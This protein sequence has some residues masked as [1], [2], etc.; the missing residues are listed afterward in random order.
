MLLDVI[1]HVADPWAFLCNLQ[2]KAKYYLFHV[3]LDL[4]AINVLREKS[5]LDVRQK[6]GHIHYFS[7]NLALS[8]MDECGYEVVQWQYSGAAFNAP[9]RTWKKVLASLPRGIAYAVDKDWGVRA[10]GGETLYILAKNRI[11]TEL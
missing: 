5:I 11:E 4:S 2:N 8:L 10:L 9:K 6:V 7:K 1:E 3:P